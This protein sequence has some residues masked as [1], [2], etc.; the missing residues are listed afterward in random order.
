M[1]RL[2]LARV[3]SVIGHPVVV[4]P[5]AVVVSGGARGV[6]ASTRSTTIGVTV[7]IGLVVLVFSAVRVRLGHWKH[8]DAS[9]PAERNQLNGFTAVLLLGAGLA[10]FLSP[11][12]SPDLYLWP[13]CSGGVVLAAIV[14]RRR[15]KL[16][17]HVAF[18]LFAAL[19]VLPSVGAAVA[20]AVLTGAVAWSRLK[21]GRHTRAEIGVGTVVG[22]VVGALFQTG[23]RFIRG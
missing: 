20:I 18:D 14:L 17:Q 22:L 12:G 7:G 1:F 13:A 21:L 11:G 10:G 8:V 3:L 15:L 19:A 5:V 4:L 6:P 23:L 16:S 9:Q 2:P